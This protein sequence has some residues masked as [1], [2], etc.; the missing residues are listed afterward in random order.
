MTIQKYFSEDRAVSPVIGVI[1]MVA[2]TVILAAVIGAFV[3]GLGDDLGSSTSP[4]VQLSYEYDGT[5]TVTVNHNGGDTIEDFE[6]KGTDGTSTTESLS[7]GESMTISPVASGDTVR[8]VIDDSVISSYEVPAESEAATNSISITD[9]T[10]A[11][12]G[13]TLDISYSTA[14]GYVVIEADAGVIYEAS[15]SEGSSNITTDGA[16]TEGETLDVTL[17]ESNSKTNPLDT[18]TALA[19]A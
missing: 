18:D 4:Q 10:A 15:I 19:G 5:D 13:V 6:I 2:I 17:Y 9:S 12:N 8:I 7:P 3:L 16:F 14:S 1:L 11:S